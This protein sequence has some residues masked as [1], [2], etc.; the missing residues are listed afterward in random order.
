VSTGA[1]HVGNARETAAMGGPELLNIGP[2]VGFELG[3][4]K[5]ADRRAENMPSS[6]AHRD[7]S[8]ADVDGY[9]RLMGRT[10]PG[11]ANERLKAHR[12]GSG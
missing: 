9:S 2:R 3:L 8:T 7:S 6:A 5:P 10:R 11:P 12:G 4:V 1:G